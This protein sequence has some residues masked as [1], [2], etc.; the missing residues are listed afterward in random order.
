MAQNQPNAG[1]SPTRKVG[2]FAASSAD[3]K[4]LSTAVI[5]I[6]SYTGEGKKKEFAESK[7]CSAESQVTLCDD[8]KGND[9]QAAYRI[10]KGFGGLSPT[11]RQ[12]FVVGANRE[13][14]YKTKKVRSP[15]FPLT[16]CLLTLCPVTGDLHHQ[17]HHECP[18]VHPRAEVSNH[19]V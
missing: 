3:F 1:H 2:A 15:P 17:G 8:T 18:Q 13:I 16:L 11:Q 5:G 9:V 4:D 10:G 12:T 14:L 19:F 6:S 7:G